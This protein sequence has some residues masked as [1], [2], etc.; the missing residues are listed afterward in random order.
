[1][2]RYLLVLGA[3]L[4]ALVLA[5]RPAASQEAV[6]ADVTCATFVVPPPEAAAGLGKVRAS[7]LEAANVHAAEVERWLEQRPGAVPVYR[8]SPLPLH[9]VLCVR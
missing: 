8:A 1:M 9:E 7:N 3:A 2:S 4:G 6:S 5:T